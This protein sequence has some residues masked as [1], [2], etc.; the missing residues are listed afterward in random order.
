MGKKN[1][2]KRPTLIKRVRRVFKQQG[3]EI[4]VGIATGLITNYFTDATENLVAK[5]KNNPGE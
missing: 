2:K 3:G 1:K 5:N 4:A